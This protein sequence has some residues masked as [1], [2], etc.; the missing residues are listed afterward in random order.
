V[1]ITYPQF[2]DEDGIITP[3]PIS[4]DVTGAEALMGMRNPCEAARI[5]ASLNATAADS[6]AAA[7]LDS[8]DL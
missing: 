1:N 6:G 7:E 2:E 8:D 3:H 4:T 5:T